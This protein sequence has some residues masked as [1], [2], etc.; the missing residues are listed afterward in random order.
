[1]Y[2]RR[3]WVE[4]PGVSFAVVVFA[5]FSSAGAAWLSLTK[6]AGVSNIAGFPPL[7]IAFCRFSIAGRTGE[8]RRGK[9]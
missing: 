9:I 3:C 8:V 6:P 2:W 4:R 7:V 1:M 5:C